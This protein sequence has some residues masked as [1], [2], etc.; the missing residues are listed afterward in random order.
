MWLALSADI[1]ANT[2]FGQA[3]QELPTYKFVPLVYQVRV[4]VGVGV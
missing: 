4:R 3:F 1:E 2:A